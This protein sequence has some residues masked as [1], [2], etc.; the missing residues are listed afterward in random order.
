MNKV[1]LSRREVCFIIGMLIGLL[2]HEPV[3]VMVNL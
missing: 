3:N 1:D 2:M